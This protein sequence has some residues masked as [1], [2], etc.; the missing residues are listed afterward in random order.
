MDYDRVQCSRRKPR[1]T[2]QSCVDH[3]VC[4]GTRGIVLCRSRN[5]EIV[6]DAASV[7]NTGGKEN[8]GVDGRE[9]YIDP[10][11]CD[12]LVQLVRYNTLD[13]YPAFCWL[14]NTKRPS[15]HLAQQ[16]RT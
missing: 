5:V 9:G 4:I 12:F 3:Q 8:G 15:L 1:G 16:P 6:Q 14:M 2:V 10:S 11:S 7:F 13:S